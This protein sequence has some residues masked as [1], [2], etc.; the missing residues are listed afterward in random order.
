M[1]KTCS[2]Q[3]HCSAAGH[4]LL[5]PAGG[6]EDGAI[7]L[8]P[9]VQYVDT[10]VTVSEQEV[11]DAMVSLLHHHSKLVEGAAGCALAACKQLGSQLAGRR[12]AVVCC[13]GNVALPVLQQVLNLGTVW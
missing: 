10:W 6:I 12:V 9:C 13:G 7:T 8:P 2:K 1:L 11:A 5:R 4:V 3:F